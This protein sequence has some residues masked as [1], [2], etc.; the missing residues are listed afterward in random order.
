MKSSSGAAE[1]VSVTGTVTLGRS[2]AVRTTSGWWVPTGRSVAAV[3][4]T[5]A[6]VVP[7]LGTTVSQFAEVSA[8]N[9]R[10]TPS[11]VPTSTDAPAAGPPWVAASSTLG[12][13]VVRR[14]ATSLSVTKTAWRT[15]T[16]V[17]VVTCAVIV[18]SPSGSSA[19]S[20]GAEACVTEPGA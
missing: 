14:A 12:R 16:P 13:E 15:T 1:T 4:E 6:G 9:A 19:V 18:C 8:V 11:D 7:A 17:A 20:N 2:A 10:A 3:R 5:W